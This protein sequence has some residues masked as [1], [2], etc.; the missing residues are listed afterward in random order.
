MLLAIDSNSYTPLQCVIIHFE[1]IYLVYTL[2]RGPRRQF[3]AISMW[4]SGKL[5][6][7]DISTGPFIVIEISGDLNMFQASESNSFF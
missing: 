3:K 4:T 5:F 1:L 2:F 6:C 7:Q